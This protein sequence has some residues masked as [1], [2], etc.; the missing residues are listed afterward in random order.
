MDTGIVDGAVSDRSSPGAVP[1]IGVTGVDD[2]PAAIAALGVGAPRP[3]LV[4]I[5]GAGGMAVE[6]ERVADSVL[7]GSVF[8]AIGAVGGAIVDGGTDTGIMRLAGRAA[9]ELARP[10]P[11]IG[12][13][14]EGRLAEVVVEPHHLGLL[15]VPGDRW[16]DESRWLVPAA[17]VIAAG[18]P[19][20]TLLL[21][22]GEVAHRE[23]LAGI[24][25]GV[26]TIVMAGSGRAANDL[27]AIGGAAAG[28]GVEIVT[29]DE[30]PRLRELLT[31]MLGRRTEEGR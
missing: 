26:P 23:A 17:R 4:L 1:V 9:A 29:V 21:N 25:D 18:L 5:G 14:P 27:A 31:T 3:V 6:D 20:V 2:L 15:A 19:V 10:L 28:Q 16:G 30:G 8:P 12:V 22:G 7:R 13:L 24:A 11:L